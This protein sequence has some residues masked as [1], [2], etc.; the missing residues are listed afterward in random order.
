MRTAVALAVT[1]WLASACSRS[2][3]IS[4]GPSIAG[5][6]AATDTTQRVMVLS[7][8]QTGV[9]VS[10]AG[11]LGDSPLV[12]T[13][14]NEISSCSC[15]CPCVYTR[16]VTLAIADPSGDTLHAE[17]ALVGIAA[18]SDTLA[19]SIF[20]RSGPPPGFPFAGPTITLVRQPHA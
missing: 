15:V 12:T 18:T 5:E 9:N 8:K 10:G 3:T 1:I 14:S 16:P 17:G 2:N 6:W 4:P 20:Q 13:G 19:L 11:T 7:L